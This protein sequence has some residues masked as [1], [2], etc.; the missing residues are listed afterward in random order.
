MEEKINL[1]YAKD[2]LKKLEKRKYEV[3]LE[4]L[5]KTEEYLNARHEL[6]VKIN[7]LERS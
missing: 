2:V 7:Q 5:P 3:E 4:K 6:S 1:K